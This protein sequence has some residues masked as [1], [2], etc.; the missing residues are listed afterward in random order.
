[1]RVLLLVLASGCLQS[2][3]P[4][5]G[6]LQTSIDGGSTTCANVDSDPAATVSFASDVRDGVFH[7]GGCT[8]CHTGDGM[9]VQQ[10]GLDLSSYATLRTGGGRSGARIV[11][12]FMPCQSILAQKIQTAPPFGRRMPYNG[13]PYLAAAD[14]QLVADWIAEGARDN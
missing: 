2:I 1:V 4:D 12:D 10:S 9:G 5:V 6:P 7:R 8:N 14:I 3:G 11:V 13:P